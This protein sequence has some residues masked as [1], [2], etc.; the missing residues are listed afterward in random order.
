VDDRRFDSLVKSLATGSSRR[1]VLKGMLGL[2]GA[3]LVGTTLSARDGSAARRPTPTPKPVTCPGVQKPAGGVCICTSPLKNCGPDCCNP[4]AQPGTANYSECCDNACC[5]GHCYGEELCCPYPREFCAVSGECC[6]GD[7]PR[8][9]PDVGC[10]AAD[11]CC[12]SEDCPGEDTLCQQRTCIDGV[13][14]LIFERAGTLLPDQTAEDCLAEICDGSGGIDTIPFNADTPPAP[15]ECATYQCHG[16]EPVLVFSDRDVPC[17]GGV[18]DGAGNCAQCFAAADC[19]GSDSECGT[20]TCQNQVCGWD[21]AAAGTPIATQVANDC[22][23]DVCDGRGG[24][25]LMFDDTDVPAEP[26]ECRTA[27]CVNGNVVRGSVDL[28]VPCSLGLCDGIGQCVQCV[29]AVNCPDVGIGTFRRC[30]NSMC[31]FECG[32]GW[33]DCNSEASD[34]CEIRTDTDPLNCGGC[35]IQCEAG[36]DCFRGAC[37]AE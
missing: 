1:A 20:K 5:A 29:S 6:G 25:T 17:T 30:V 16:G 15:S 18:C 7:T 10:V 34:G 28:G 37:I 33:A 13:C 12:S 11:V 3:A 24:V 26:N 8:C 27:V 4:T 22:R 14:D 2:G 9:C 35:G 36:Q 19:P 32:P 21:Y 31:A 23:L